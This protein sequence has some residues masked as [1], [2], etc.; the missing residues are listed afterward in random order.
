MVLK[1]ATFQSA[2]AWNSNTNFT[3]TRCGG[4]VDD[5]KR[6]ATPCRTVDTV[7]LTRHRHLEQLGIELE[8]ALFSGNIL[9]S[10]FRH[11][12]R[13]QQLEPSAGILQREIFKARRYAGALTARIQMMPR[14]G[15]ASDQK[16]NKKRLKW[17]A[18]GIFA[19]S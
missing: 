17:I 15:P 2:S 1:H 16:C 4:C 7:T 9:P 11:E 8:A 19:R 14:L 6:W 18:L 3:G 5:I 12:P 13:K 10:K